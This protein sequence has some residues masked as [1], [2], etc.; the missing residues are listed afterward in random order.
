M[1]YI[2]I[3]IEKS[4][5]EIFV[6]ILNF[7]YKNIVFYNFYKYFRIWVTIVKTNKL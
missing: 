5:P 6:Q 1:V 3:G 2:Y 7:V 4:I